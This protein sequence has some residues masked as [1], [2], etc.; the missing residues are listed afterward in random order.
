MYLLDIDADLIFESSLRMHPA[1]S[2]YLPNDQSRGPEISLDEETSKHVLQVLRMKPGE[3]IRLTNGAGLSLRATI[4][5]SAIKKC[6][7][8][9]MESILQP[10]PGRKISIGISLLKNTG[11]F[12]WFLEKATEIGVNELIPLICDRTEKHK[13]R[14]DRMKSILVSAMLQSQQS[15][16][17]EISEP[18]EFK[19]LVSESAHQ[20]KFIAHCERPDPL[21]LSDL[22]NSNL[23]TQIILIGP[24]GDFTG[25]E[26][27]WAFSHHFIP[28]SLGENRLRSETAGV[29]AATIM[30]I[31]S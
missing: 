7:V 10:H 12:E 17:P 18:K 2:F 15:W 4:K 26:L 21:N 13:L 9:V 3:E 5:P 28:V 24:E 31:P 8:T 14:L 22:V 25:E 11:R 6:K 29:V 1:P 20:Q 23:S 30:K 19:A 27:A 16:L